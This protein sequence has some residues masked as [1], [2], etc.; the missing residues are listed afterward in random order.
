MHEAG[1]SLTDSN[2]MRDKCMA[3]MCTH[4]PTRR[5]IGERSDSD[6]SSR[7]SLYCDCAGTIPLPLNWNGALQS[8]SFE[9]ALERGVSAEVVAGLSVDEQGERLWGYRSARGMHQRENC[10]KHRTN[11]VVCHAHCTLVVALG[12]CLRE[13]SIVAGGFGLLVDVHSPPW[14]AASLPC[15]APTPA[16]QRFLSP[17]AES[18]LL[19]ADSVIIGSRS[20]LDAPARCFALSAPSGATDVLALRRGPSQRNFSNGEI[21]GQGEVAVDWPEWLALSD[22]DG[23]ASNLRVLQQVS[24]DPPIAFDES[25]LMAVM[26]HWMLEP[27]TNNGTDT[28]GLRCSP[29][30]LRLYFQSADQVDVA[31][32]CIVIQSC[33]ASVRAALRDTARRILFL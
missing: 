14:S 28:E 30:C 17:T 31:L 19:Q 33:D 16:T 7:C 3:H 4:P 6:V 1:V 21:N 8:S 25:F 22:D 18:K 10:A 13:S 2:I 12:C 9:R 32:S 11:R 27:H 5:E 23:P 26:H 24:L 15:V 29:V 20:P